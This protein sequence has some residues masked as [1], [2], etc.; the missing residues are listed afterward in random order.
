MKRVMLLSVVGIASL[1]TQGT[2]VAQNGPDSKKDRSSQESRGVKNSANAADASTCKVTKQEWMNFMASEFD[3][4]ANNSGEI[5]LSK[6]REENGRI[7]PF[8]SLG[9]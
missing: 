8:S 3:R 9:K 1:F 5:D 7:V 6:R 2:A 4:L